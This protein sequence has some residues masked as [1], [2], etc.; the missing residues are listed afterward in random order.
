MELVLNCP[1]AAEAVEVA[2]RLVLFADLERG[3]EALVLVEAA[4]ACGPPAD[5]ATLAR[6]WI[7]EGALLTDAGDPAGGSALY[8][9]ARR[10]GPGVWIAAFGPEKQA[11]YEA[12]A[13][14]RGAGTLTLDGTAGTRGTTWVDGGVVEVPSL[15]SAGAHLVQ[16]GADG[17]VRFAQVVVV[18]DAQVLHV[19]V[20]PD[21]HPAPPEPTAVAPAVPLARSPI[22]LVPLSVPTGT[23]PYVHLGVGTDLSF[24]GGVDRPMEFGTNEA[25]MTVRLPLELGGGA[26]GRHGWVRAAVSAAPVLSGAATSPF[27][28]G[29]H[30]A[31]GVC[32][33]PVDIGLLGGYSWSEVLTTRVVLGVVLPGAPIELEVRAGLNVGADATL[34]RAASVVIAFPGTRRIER[35]HPAVGG[36]PQ[37]PPVAAQP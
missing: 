11:Q 32:V 34:E 28:A 4:F 9:S 13:L 22:A 27:E 14:P 23:H 33:G 19:L 25:G 36:P 29:G 15:I 16:Y 2:E 5:A 18:S 10:T 8:A 24:G 30:L 12:A 37:I 1:D 17:H 7:V 21:P 6:M 3:K 20:P 26:A 35:R 31:G